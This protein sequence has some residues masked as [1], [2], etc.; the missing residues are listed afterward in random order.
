MQ[1]LT[2][3]C[4]KSFILSFERENIQLCTNGVCIFLV[5]IILSFFNT[6]HDIL[7]Q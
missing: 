1:K 4:R 7:R 5:L 3:I 6:G 2:E